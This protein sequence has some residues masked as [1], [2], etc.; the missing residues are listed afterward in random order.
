MLMTPAHNPWQHY[1][2]NLPAEQL[3]FPEEGQE[4]VLHLRAA[5]PLSA[6]ATVLDYG[7]GYGHA[8]AAL[9]P[10]VG[11]VWV[12]DQAPAML[13]FTLNA[14]ARVSN[15]QLWEPDSC[16]VRFDLIWLN[17]VV[18]YMTEEQLQQTLLQ[19]V[20]HLAL[21]GRMVLSDL[22]PPGHNFQKDVRSLLW[23]SLRK[24]YLLKA[25]RKTRQVA[26]QYEQYKTEQ[27]LLRSSLERLSAI[28]AEVQCTLDVLPRNLTHFRHRT[29]VV[30]R[31]A[32]A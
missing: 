9:A 20:P 15:V 22:I 25:V 1:W 27:P 12:W 2:Q 8:A 16:D 19:L 11:Q 29:A 14:L 18:Q 31:S 7:C 5:M 10:Y 21:G 24:G 32:S 28:A 6:D 23:F 13:D 3:Y 4:A 30:L 26:K 17:S